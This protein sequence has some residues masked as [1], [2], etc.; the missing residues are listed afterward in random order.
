MTQPIQQFY[1]VIRLP[2]RE[3][4]YQNVLDDNIDI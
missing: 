1:R 3:A 4:R 2:S